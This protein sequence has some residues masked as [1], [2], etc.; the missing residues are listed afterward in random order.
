MDNDEPD[1]EPIQS[2]TS[3]LYIAI[4]STVLVCILFVAI[5]IAIY[6]YMHHS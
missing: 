5:G 4:A 3:P 2:T 6:A 1:T